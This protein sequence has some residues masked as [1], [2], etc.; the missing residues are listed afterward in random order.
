M[1]EAWENNF[2]MFREWAYQNGYTPE[3]TIDRIDSALLYSPKTCRWAT[4]AVQARNRRALDNGTS[5]YIGVYRHSANE[6][7]IAQIQV[8][9][10]NTYLG[11]YINE[12]DAALARDAFIKDNSLEGY[13]FNFK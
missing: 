6:C 10:K 1:C 11:S 8:D 13:T 2:S 3:L 5:R 7:F 9:G 4:K 12:I